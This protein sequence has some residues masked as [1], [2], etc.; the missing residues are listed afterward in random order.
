MKPTFIWNLII[1][2]EKDKSDVAAWISTPPNPST[3]ENDFL[4]QAINL[5][6]IESY[7]WPKYSS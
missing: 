5:I 2:I 3:I 7:N 4:L 1:F 6:D